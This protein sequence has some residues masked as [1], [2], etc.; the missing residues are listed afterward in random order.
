MATKKAA[1]QSKATAAAPMITVAQELHVDTDLR[2]LL[3]ACS[4]FGEQFAPFA[5]RVKAELARVKEGEQ[6]GVPQIPLFV[7]GEVTPGELKA[8]CN[9]ALRPYPYLRVIQLHHCRIGDDGVLTLCEFLQRYE[10]LP[11]H[12]PFGI[13]RLELPGCDIGPRGCRRLGTFLSNN[14]TVEGLVLDFNPLQDAGVQELCNGLRWNSSVTSLSLQYCDIGPLG[15][16]HLASHVVKEA[17]VSTLSLRGNHVGDPGL[18][19][20]S[21]AICVTSK[22]A[23]LDLADTGCGGDTAAVLSLCEAIESTSTLRVVDVDMNTFSLSATESL[24]RSFQ[25]SKSVK[26]LRIG[27]RTDAAVY[28]QI[29]DLSASRSSTGKGKKKRKKKS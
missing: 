3:E 21:K 7:R 20:I 23:D 18:D 5:K 28:K 24:L 10:P 22:I 1:A 15:A 2:R 8:L 19:E 6:T 26:T 12:N 9:D 4:A 16:D 25:A 17:N 11:D 13:Q 29:V 14:A 27:E